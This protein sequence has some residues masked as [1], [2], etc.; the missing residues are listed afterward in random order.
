MPRSIRST[1]LSWYALILLLVLGSFGAALIISQRRSLLDQLQVELEAHASAL[2]GAVEDEADGFEFEMARQYLGIF[3]PRDPQGPYFVIWNRHGSI[4]FASHEK[5]DVPRPGARGVRNRGGSLEISRPGTDGTWV[6]VGQSTA[7]V[8]E[9]VAAFSGKV[10]ATGAAVLL[11]SL[12]GGWMLAGRV[13][14]PIRRI[15]EAA[16]DIS[17]GNLVRRID[18]QSTED[19]L[20]KLAGVLNEAFD[21]LQGAIERQTRFTADASHELR[22]PLSVILLNTEHSLSRDRD[23]ADYKEALE[24]IDRAGRRMKSLIAV[25]L[26]MARADSGIDSAPQECIDM[27]K[28]V[29]E[30]L[31]LVQP[32]AEERGV[33]LKRSTMP[34]RVQGNRDL[35]L[36]M[37][38]NLLS[39]AILHNRRGGQ[40]RVDLM[41]ENGSVLFEVKD[42][43]PGI[44]DEDLP[45]VFERFYRVDKA[46]TRKTGGSGLGLAITKW[47]V[48]VHGGSISVASRPDK[49]TVFSV[50]LPPSKGP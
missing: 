24:A 42:D 13:L 36:E 33:V 11:I 32:L 37:A 45:H 30:T 35:I 31:E 41:V 5:P 44:A 12:I 7:S 9:A 47:I 14:R 39:N 43:G 17:E 50:R 25:L 34:A 29:E 28:V 1:L 15:S 4:G 40:G 2:A 46:R 18:L 22:T 6:V 3:D 48:E 49:G 23:A 21:R 16:T 19:E 20:G 27:E 8:R 10:A 38:T 26:S